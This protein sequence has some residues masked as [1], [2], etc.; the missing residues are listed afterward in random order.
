MSTTKEYPVFIFAAIKNLSSEQA[1]SLLGRVSGFLEGWNSHGEPIHAEAR[2]EESRFL[3]VELKGGTASGCSKDKLFRMLEEAPA[4]LDIQFDSS[5][6]FF[7]EWKNEIISMSRKELKDNILN[8][9]FRENAR[10]F[11][12]WISSLAE[13]RMQWKKPLSS[14]PH[15]FPASTLV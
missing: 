1:K 15:L 5:G 4:M 7:I 12:I 11:P 2:V 6:K 9:E 14:F 3:V 13:Y 10:L 8:S